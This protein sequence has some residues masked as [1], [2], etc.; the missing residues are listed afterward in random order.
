MAK[1][2]PSVGHRA[3]QV[4]VQAY[5]TSF[6]LCNLEAA[7]GFKINAYTRDEIFETELFS[8]KRKK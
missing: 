1:K 3:L 8:Q 4:G 6:I 5:I 7:A 2:K